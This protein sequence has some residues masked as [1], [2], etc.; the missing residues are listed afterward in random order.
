MCRPA[1]QQT[2]GR[3]IPKIIRI[4]DPLE[5]QYPMLENCRLGLTESVHERYWKMRHPS[6]LLA[7]GRAILSFQPSMLK[8]PENVKINLR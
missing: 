5:I 6:R 2:P 1:A 4:G 8:G 3:S 7:L